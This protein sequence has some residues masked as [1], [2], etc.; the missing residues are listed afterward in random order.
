MLGPQN[1]I[2]FTFCNYVNSRRRVQNTGRAKFGVK[3]LTVFTC[4]QQVTGIEKS[5]SNYVVEKKQTDR[6]YNE[7]YNWW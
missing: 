4:A 2:N 7:D 3:E 6:I 1:K 5:E